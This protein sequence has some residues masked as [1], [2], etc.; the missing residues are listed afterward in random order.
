MSSLR[1]A[2]GELRIWFLKILNAFVAFSFKSH[3]ILC[4]SE[5]TPSEELFAS[6]LDF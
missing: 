1:K 2:E 4:R 6:S 5:V 3:Q